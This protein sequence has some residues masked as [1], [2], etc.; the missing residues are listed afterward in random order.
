MGKTRPTRRKDAKQARKAARHAEIYSATATTATASSA[1]DGDSANELLARAAA[2]LQ[3]GD[4]DSALPYAQKAEALLVR[5]KSPATSLLPVLSLL[6]EI[7]VEAGNPEAALAA[8]GRAAELDPEGRIPET[9]GGGAEKF[10]W[11]AQLS[12]HGGRESIERY[13]QG[14]AILER[15]IVADEGKADKDAEQEERR[16][17]LASALCSMIEVWMTD[18]S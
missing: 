16:R 4:P 17:K 14:I 9:E 5:S 3:I 12:E 7:H 13:E 8:F 1:D 18:L 10:F 2:Q 15:L 11:L 6:G